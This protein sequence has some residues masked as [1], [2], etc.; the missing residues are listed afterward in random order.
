MTNGHRN[1][2][3]NVV[4]ATIPTL[5]RPPTSPTTSALWNSLSAACT[6]EVHG[7]RIVREAVTRLRNLK[8][9]YSKY[10]KSLGA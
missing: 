10:E 3:E 2:V 1:N 9:D 4:V 6:I 8:N 5:S 7:V